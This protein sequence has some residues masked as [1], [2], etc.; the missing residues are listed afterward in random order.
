MHIQ[1]QG[2]PKWQF[3][4]DGGDERSMEGEGRWEILFLEAT[5]EQHWWPLKI[6]LIVTSC[7]L[8]Y[9]WFSSERTNGCIV[10]LSMT[11]MRILW[12]FV[13]EVLLLSVGASVI[14]SNLGTF[15]WHVSYFHQRGSVIVSCCD[16]DSYGHFVMFSGVGTWPHCWWMEGEGETWRSLVWSPYGIVFGLKFQILNQTD[17]PVTE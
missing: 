5:A 9:Q 8:M 16:Y 15:H 17:L 12:C 2:L 13:V 7:L 14:N 4:S 10:Q 6:G 3:H 11:V 1:D